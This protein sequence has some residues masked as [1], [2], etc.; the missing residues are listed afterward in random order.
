[1]ITIE[2]NYK[3]RLM[4]EFNELSDKINK[5]T[6]FIKTEKFEELEIS[7]QLLMKNQLLF[8]KGYLQTV[9][10]RINLTMTKNEIN[11]IEELYAKSK[12]N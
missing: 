3:S 8:M 9:Y 5:L 1:M 11:K 10:D 6:S 12:E 7:I 4:L 2:K